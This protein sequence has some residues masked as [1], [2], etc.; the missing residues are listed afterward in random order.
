MSKSRRVSLP[1]FIR[2]TVDRLRETQTGLGRTPC[3]VG[4]G[5]IWRTFPTVN[6][7]F[8]KAWQPVIN[9]TSKK[10]RIETPRSAGTSAARTGFRAVRKEELCLSAVPRSPGLDKE[11]KPHIKTRTHKF[12]KSF[13]LLGARPLSPGR[14]IWS[15]IT[16]P[17]TLVGNLNHESST[18]V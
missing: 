15:V 2:V 16:A 13:Q 12:S 4:E 8:R 17:S 18:G 14:A 1:V 5:H 3:P 6:G 10:I 7:F 11:A 9:P